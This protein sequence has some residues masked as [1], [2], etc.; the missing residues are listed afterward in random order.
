MG[1]CPRPYTAKSRSLCGSRTH[2]GLGGL[3]LLAAKA[4][5]TSG[6][7][8]R[9]HWG[10]EGHMGRVSDHAAQR[11]VT[12]ALAVTQHLKFGPVPHIFQT[13]VDI[14]SLANEAY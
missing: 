7:R 1:K 5:R 13:P 4:R 8:I 6:E 2:C 11:P 14:C 9:Q 3:N 10:Q 12:V